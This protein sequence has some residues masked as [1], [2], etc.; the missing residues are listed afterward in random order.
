MKKPLFVAALLAA[1]AL[2]PLAAQK[3]DASA[4]TGYIGLKKKDRENV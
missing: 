2:L 3:I 4:S 1:L